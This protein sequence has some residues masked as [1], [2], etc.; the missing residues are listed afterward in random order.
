MKIPKVRVTDE[1][2]RSL[3]YLFCSHCQYNYDN[4]MNDCEGC[5]M[6]TAENFKKGLNQIECENNNE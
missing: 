5:F 3:Y 6:E 1:T 4:N 2:M